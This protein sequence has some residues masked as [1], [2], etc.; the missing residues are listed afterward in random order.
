METLLKDIRYGFRSLRKRPGFAAVAIITLALGIGANTAIF[1]LVNAVMLKSLPV[2]RPEELV[3]FTKGDI[4]EGTTAGD[5]IVGEWQLYSNFAYQYQR[6]HNSSFQDIL[7]LRSGQ[8]RLSVSFPGDAAAQRAQGQL[9]SGNYFSVLGVSAMLGRVLTPDDDKPNASPA[10]VISNRYWQETLNRD[11]AVVGRNVTING[12]SFT[13]VGVTPAEF[14]GE[15]V[16]QPPDFWVPLAFQPQIELRPSILDKKDMYFLTL[17]GRL[18]PGVGIEAARASTNLAL[19]QFLTEEA[20]GKLTEARQRDIQN[21]SAF[22]IPGGQG[23]SPLRFLYSKPLQMLMA[24]VGMVLLIA[25][26]NA[27]SLFLSR[28]ASRRPEMSLRLA[29]GA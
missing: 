3:L 1:T 5:P 10:A 25:C 18:N 24:I 26:A 22:L 20:G 9:V 27:G 23:I 11:G 8:S 12:T 6:E 29:L 13:I 15:R 7:A 14:F 17:I 21:T 2:T 28:A 19:R 16:R 4:G